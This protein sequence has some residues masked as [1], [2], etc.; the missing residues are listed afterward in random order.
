ML[1]GKKINAFLHFQQQP[2]IKHFSAFF[3]DKQQEC[4]IPTY[5]SGSGASQSHL[6]AAP[7]SSSLPNN[8]ATAAALQ[9]QSIIS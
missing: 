8:A 5:G 1:K 9:V 7:S 4:D 6:L 3:S 2:K